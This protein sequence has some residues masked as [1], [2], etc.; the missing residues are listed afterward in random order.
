MCGKHSQT[1]S[2]TRDERGGLHSQCARCQHDLAAIVIE[3]GA[4][5]DI[6]HY[7]ARAALHRCAARRHAGVNRIEEIQKRLL[8]AP[9]HKDFQIF[10]RVVQ[11]LNISHISPRHLNRGVKNVAEQRGKVALADQLRADVVQAPHR[12]EIRGYALF[13]LPAQRYIARRTKP[14]HDFGISIQKGN[15]A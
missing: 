8:E 5:G 4:A 6:I 11:Q 10:G 2:G 7:D 1:F 15:G 3:Q 9:L 14:L 13:G 12:G